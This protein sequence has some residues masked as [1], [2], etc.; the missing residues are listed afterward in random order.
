VAADCLLGG[1]LTA[2]RRQ[3]GRAGLNAASGR[4]VGQVC[5]NGAPCQNG[6]RGDQKRNHG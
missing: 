5:A 6:F 1:E 4:N 3:S 2:S